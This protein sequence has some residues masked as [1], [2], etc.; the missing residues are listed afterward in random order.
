MERFEIEGQS[1]ALD[2]L[3][4][5]LRPLNPSDYRL[6]GLDGGRLIV[7]CDEV[8]DENPFQREHRRDRRQARVLEIIRAGRDGTNLRPDAFK[9]RRLPS[10]GD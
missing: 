9:V 8:A 4:A 10:E 6:L 3:R 7:E 2:Q 1:D 5:G